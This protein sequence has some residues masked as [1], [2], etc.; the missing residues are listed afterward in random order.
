MVQQPGVMALIDW[1]KQGL[2]N[3]QYESLY[4]PIFKD[5]YM[6]KLCCF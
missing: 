3:S 5:N 4:I 1:I 2:L 6:K